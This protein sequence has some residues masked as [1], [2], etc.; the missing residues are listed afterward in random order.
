[1]QFFKE[2][3]IL[4]KI[5]AILTVA[6]LSFAINLAISL[7]SI[8]KNQILLEE[9]QNTAIHLVNL[10]SENLTSWQRIDESYTQSVSFG[11]EDLIEDASLLVNSLLT[12]IE[13][14]HSLK[15][16]FS[17]AQSL[18]SHITKYNMI[19]KEISLGFINEEI[20]FQALREKSNKKQI[21]LK[22]L[23]KFYYLIS[24]QLP[25]SLTA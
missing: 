4:Y 1:M 24:K 19:A 22:R 14:I 21:L 9:V 6:L 25:L 18:K 17:D 5:Y 7:T 8:S 10:T 13:K 2:L 12:S 15:A 20:D 23:V 16:D 11:D 3:R